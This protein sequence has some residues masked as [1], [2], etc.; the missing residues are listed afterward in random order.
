LQWY[1]SMQRTEMSNDVGK[2]R[3]GSRNNAIPQA[4]ACPE[5]NHQTPL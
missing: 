3:N 2:I 1:L 4:T 5:D